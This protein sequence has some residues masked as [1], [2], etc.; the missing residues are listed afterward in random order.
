MLTIHNAHTMGATAIA[1]TRDC[2][3]IVS[4]GGE[5][6]VSGNNINEPIIC[7]LLDIYYYF[8]YILILK[9]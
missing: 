8:I 9:S 6:Q 2:K 7:S 3:R 5:G 1:G 4:G